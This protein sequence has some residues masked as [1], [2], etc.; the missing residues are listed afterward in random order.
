MYSV[1]NKLREGERERASNGRDEREEERG[2][3]ARAS[4]SWAS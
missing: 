4:S 2:L 1:S 3:M